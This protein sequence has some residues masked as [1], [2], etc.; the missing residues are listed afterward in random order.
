MLN[1]DDSDA[2]DE[3]MTNQGIGSFFTR[4]CDR[5]AASTIAHRFQRI[6]GCRGGR[7]GRRLQ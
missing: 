7:H 4:D 6:I 3:M 5:E 1:A 2:D